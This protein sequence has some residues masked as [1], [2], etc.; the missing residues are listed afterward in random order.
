MAFCSANVAVLQ[1]PGYG[2]A[3]SELTRVCERIR[4]VPR[5]RISM[6]H[7]AQLCCATARARLAGHAGRLL[8]DHTQRCVADGKQGVL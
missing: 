2:G 7:A 5:A 1:L 8:Q 3:F 4:H 6:P